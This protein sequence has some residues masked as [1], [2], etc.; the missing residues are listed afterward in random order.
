MRIRACLSTSILLFV[1]AFALS[2]ACA[3]PADNNS[4]VRTPIIME[5]PDAYS[6]GEL[7][8]LKRTASSNESEPGS[9][10]HSPAR[11][12][13]RFPPGTRAILEIGF[14]GS[15]HMSDLKRLH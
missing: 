13:L 1:F 11:G 6:M 4:E 12:R 5:F 9:I 10:T 8:I 3:A 15:Q 14:D 2:S 7:Y